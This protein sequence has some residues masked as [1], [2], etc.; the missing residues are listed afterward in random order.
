MILGDPLRGKV[1]CHK[2][3]ARYE[4]VGSWSGPAG[5]GLTPWRGKARLC[6]LS[7]RVHQLF[8]HEFVNAVRAQFAADSGALGTTER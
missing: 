2:P 5:Q 6:K 3:K 4:T 8:V 7:G 1:T